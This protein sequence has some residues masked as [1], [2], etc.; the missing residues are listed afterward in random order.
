MLGQTFWLHRERGPAETYTALGE[1]AA[2]GWANGDGPI[3][4]GASAALGQREPGVQPGDRST[5]A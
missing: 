4:W 3:V 2:A 5:A 1:L